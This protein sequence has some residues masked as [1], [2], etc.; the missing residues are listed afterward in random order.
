MLTLITPCYEQNCESALNLHNYDQMYQA[1]SDYLYK[2]VPKGCAVSLLAMPF[3]MGGEVGAQERT[4]S[5]GG[6]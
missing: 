1:W 3:V 4:L 5:V 2:Q 6:E